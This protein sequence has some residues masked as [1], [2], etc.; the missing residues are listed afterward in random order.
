MEHRVQSAA[1]ICASLQL[2]SRSSRP[3]DVN[4]SQKENPYDV[5]E[6]PVQNPEVQRHAIFFVRGGQL[7]KTHSQVLSTDHDVGPVKTSGLIERA[8]KDTVTE[9]ERRSSVLQVLAIHEEDSLLNCVL[10]LKLTKRLLPAIQGVFCRVCSKVGP[11]K[12][13]S[14]GFRKASPMNRDNPN[15]WPTHPQLD[16]RHLRSI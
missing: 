12:K 15:R 2:N 16:S 3:P 1:T 14:V 7:E 9:S 4:D 11:K 10:L 8:T 5:Y 13:E 6:V